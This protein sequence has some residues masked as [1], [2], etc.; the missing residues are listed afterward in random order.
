MLYQCESL[1]VVQALQRKEA[2]ALRVV[3]LLLLSMGDDMMGGRYLGLLR[4]CRVRRQG[5]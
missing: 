5:R 4:W 3:D 1:A 2:K